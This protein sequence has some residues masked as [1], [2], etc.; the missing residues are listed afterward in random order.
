MKRNPI[1]TRAGKRQ[2]IRSLTGAISKAACA[3]VPQMPAE[4][5]G[6]E[7]RAVLSELFAEEISPRWGMD[8]R[9]VR[10]YR[11]ARALMWR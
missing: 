5:D 1:N 11:N 10:A 8:R 4:W 3:A 7:L 6:H 9:R 2:F